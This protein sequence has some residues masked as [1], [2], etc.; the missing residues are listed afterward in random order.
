MLYGSENSYVGGAAIVAL[1]MSEAGAKVKFTSLISNDKYGRFVKRELKKNI[2]CNFFY[3]KIDLQ[4]I[5]IYLCPH[6]IDC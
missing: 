1:H 2:K 4:Q 6:P 5:K 3:E